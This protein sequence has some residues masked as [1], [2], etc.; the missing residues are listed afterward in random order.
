MTVKSIDFNSIRF[1]ERQSLFFFGRGRLEEQIL[2]D[3]F[4]VVKSDLSVEYMRAWRTV[5]NDASI[6][7]I[8][9]GPV[10]RVPLLLLMHFN[11][12]F[13]LIIY[14]SESLVQILVK[15]EN[16]YSLIRVN[17]LLFYIR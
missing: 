12:R 8:R 5:E 13:S 10:T 6:S 17:L 3:S 1:I 16:P 11:S 9:W 14:S 2:E 4:R 7:S 15:P